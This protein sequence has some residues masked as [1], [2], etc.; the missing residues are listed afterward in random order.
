MA[1]HLGG[2]EHA[3]RA[4]VLVSPPEKSAHKKAVKQLQETCQRSAF[5][6]VK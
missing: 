4:L 5:Y 3:L 2:E 1:D 6:L